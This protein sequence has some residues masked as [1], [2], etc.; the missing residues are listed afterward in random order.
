M[1]ATL[2]SQIFLPFAL[3]IIMLS[4]GMSLKLS[5]FMRVARQP[6]P[7]FLGILTQLLMLPVLGWIVVQLFNLPPLLAAGLMIL[8]FA[9]GGATS[10]AIT[11]LARGDAA[12]SVSLTAINSLIIPFTLP[13]LTA[14][15]LSWLSLEA[16]L[17]R[18]PVAQ[19]IG[20]M[21]LITLLPVILGM[22]FSQYCSE[23]NRKLR[24]LFRSL[25]LIL[26]L[27]TVILLV[28]SSWDRLTVLLPQLA[29]P[30]LVLVLAAMSL[31]YVL[32][33]LVGLDEPQQITLL[34]E[35]GLQN[36]GTALLVTSTLL[37]SPE[38]SASA[39][40]YGVLMQLP[41]LLLIAWRNRFWLFGILK[42]LSVGN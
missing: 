15:I 41:A 14:L 24:A 2:V 6:V 31:G 3:F 12:L 13:L 5:D 25:A 21:I 29:L 4:V 16:T 42:Q 10:N 38:M 20:Q 19:A 11:L 37:Q 30:V 33:R 32:A 23:L 9:P 34:V 36:A 40:V 27:M 35:V 39:L 8:T 1:Q 18:F 7:V 28:V 17:I 22:L 26:M